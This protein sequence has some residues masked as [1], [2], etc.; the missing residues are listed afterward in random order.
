M[1]YLTITDDYLYNHK[2][3][4]SGYTGV[5]NHKALFAQ[6]MKSGKDLL[7]LNSA[8]SYDYALQECER[9][10]GFTYTQDCP[11]KD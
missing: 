11:T 10:Y 8:D 4:P 5:N 9:E 6:V 2:D 7:G 3:Y 1:R